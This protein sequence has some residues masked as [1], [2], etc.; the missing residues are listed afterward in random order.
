M[1]CRKKASSMEGYRRPLP[2]GD[3][4]RHL[5]GDPGIFNGD[6]KVFVGDPK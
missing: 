6:P 2:T 1:K 3:P 5:T 4:Y